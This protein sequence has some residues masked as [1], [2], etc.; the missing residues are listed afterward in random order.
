MT[1]LLLGLAPAF[2]LLSYIVWVD[3]RQPEPFDKLLKTLLFGVASAFL[4]FCFSAPL[5]L[6]GL[7][8]NSP[9]SVFSALSTSLFGAAIPE[10]LAKLIML[11]LVVRKNKFFDERLDGI[12]YATC[13]GLGFAGFENVLYLLE[14]GDEVISTSVLRGLLAVPGHFC[15]AVFMGYW[16]SRWWWEKV[17]RGMGAMR[18][19]RNLAMAIVIPIILHTGYDWICFSSGIITDNEVVKGILILCLFVVCCFF[20]NNA[21]KRLMS[22]LHEDQTQDITEKAEMHLG[23]YDPEK[24]YRIFT[25]QQI[26]VCTLLG[27]FAAVL[28]TS[29]NCD[30]YQDL[31]G[32]N[33]IWMWGTLSAVVMIVIQYVTGISGLGNMVVLVTLLLTILVLNKHKGL[34]PVANIEPMK[35]RDCIKPCL[36]GIMLYLTLVIIFILP[37]F[38]HDEMVRL[39]EDTKAAKE[40]VE[41]MKLSEHHDDLVALADRKNVMAMCALAVESWEMGKDAEAKEWIEKA[42]KKGGNTQVADIL[43]SMAY[44]YHAM[45]K[46]ELAASLLKHAID[47]FPEEAKLYDSYGEMLYL[48]GQKEKALEMWNQVLEIDPNVTDHLKNN[49]SNL[50]RYLKEDGLI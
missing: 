29:S 34:I 33:F 2:M 9:D 50:S 38:I 27:P 46:Y 5:S 1:E 18:D 19:G 17:D 36:K 10:E 13:I 45:K 22:H 6:M 40:Y 39:R 41:K 15:F 12:V 28:M 8:S 42:K 16:F 3:R 20:H 35:K 37:L 25:L 23:E 49:E 30:V 32:K 47:Q 14:A 48:M 4:S 26:L 44:N 31:K 24:K 21:R 7:Y 43:N 11:Y